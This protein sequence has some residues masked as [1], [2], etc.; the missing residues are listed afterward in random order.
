MSGREPIIH[1]VSFHPVKGEDISLH[2]IIGTL[3]INSGF[4]SLY[5]NTPSVVELEIPKNIGSLS[6]LL[7][8]T[9]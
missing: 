1:P 8:W 9:S 5:A 7:A 6:I 4:P 2:P 3:R